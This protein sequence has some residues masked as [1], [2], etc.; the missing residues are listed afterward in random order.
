MLYDYLGDEGEEIQGILQNI[1][2]YGE[3]AALD[4]WLAY[5]EQEL[6]FPFEAVVDEWQEHGSLRAGDKVRVHAI[7]DADEHVRHHRQ[8][9]AWP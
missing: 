9:P 4:V 5:L 1:D 2:P 3:L 8:T 7:E 6:K